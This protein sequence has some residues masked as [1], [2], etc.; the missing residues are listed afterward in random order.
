MLQS[1]PDAARARFQELQAAGEREFFIDETEFNALGYRFLQQEGKSSEAIAV[2]EMNSRGLPRFLE[3]LGQPGRS[4]VGA[5][6]DSTRPK[7][8]MSSRWSSIP[9][10]TAGRTAL[11]RIRLDY[12][13]RDER[14]REIHPRPEDQAERPLPRPDAS[15]PGAHGVC[16]GHRLHGREFRIFHRLQPRRQGDLFYPA[17]GPGRAEHDDGLP[18]G[19]GRL[20]RPRRGRF[21]QGLPQQR[22]AYHPGREKTLFRLQPPAPGRGTG[23]V[24]QHL[25]DGTDRQTAG[26]NPA[27]TAGACT[28]LRPAR[29]TCT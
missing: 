24:R 27:T 10:A 23:R 16:P 19:E 12:Q 5:E 2:F 3:R 11:N 14:D 1:G 17:P 18:L 13:E 6:R 21:L 9:T 20:D 4:V 22:T 15:R 8:A 29:A 7:P 25:G 28:S 26:A